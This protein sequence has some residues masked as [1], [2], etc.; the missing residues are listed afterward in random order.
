M[1][2]KGNLQD[3]WPEE[4]RNLTS[5]FYSTAAQKRT[6][7]YRFIPGASGAMV[8]YPFAEKCGRKPHVLIRVTDAFTQRIGANRILSI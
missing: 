6:T 5:R 8:D 7:R 1:T 3:Y 2:F 4:E